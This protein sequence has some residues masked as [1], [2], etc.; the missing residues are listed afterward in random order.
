M[1]IYL[2]K[3]I[4]ENFINDGIDHIKKHKW[5]Y[6]LGAGALGA[7]VYHAAGKGYL[8][9]KAQGLHDKVEDKFN[10]PQSN[11]HRT[12]HPES[13]QQN[14]EHFNMGE[15]QDNIEHDGSY[16][17]HF[18]ENTNIQKDENSNN[19]ESGI[20]SHL[21]NN[22]GKYALAGTAA[23][24]GGIHLAGRG[25]LGVGP[26]DAIQDFVGSTSHHLNSLANANHIKAHGDATYEIY[27]KPDNIIAGSDERAMTSAMQN[28]IQ[29][30]H[31]IGDAQEAG[32][33]LLR[34]VGAMHDSPDMVNYMIRHPID[35][36]EQG[37]DYVSDAA[38][39]LFDRS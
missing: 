22:A 37:S 6:A 5:K 23:G 10:H 9:E 26:Q 3:I 7:G 17:N 31:Y 24:L 36:I 34:G 8:G 21:R 29:K 1:K 39:A 25:Y 2:K 16:L 13:T 35:N 28:A 30:E 11:Y 18:S 38:S 14:Q 19:E 12:E 33:S 20:I 4:Q 15:H 32:A 27:S